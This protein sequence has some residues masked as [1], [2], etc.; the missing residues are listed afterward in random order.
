MEAERFDELA[1]SWSA[2]LRLRGLVAAAAALASVG[3]RDGSIYAREAAERKRCRS[4]P[5]REVKRAIRKAK[6][7]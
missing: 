5:E 7:V 3:L 1:R 6:G 4:E 2:R